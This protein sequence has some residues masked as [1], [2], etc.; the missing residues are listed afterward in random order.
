M[1]GDVR[2]IAHGTIAGYGAP[3]STPGTLPHLLRVLHCWRHDVRELE[4]AIAAIA[5][6]PTLLL[7]GTRDRAVDPASAPELQQRLHRSKLVWLE[8]MGHLPY[9]ETPAEFNRAV[10]DF[11]SSTG[12]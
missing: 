8:G 4:K 1:Y 3:L 9:E 11:L 6:V 10:I 5:D 12:S 7:W 2:R